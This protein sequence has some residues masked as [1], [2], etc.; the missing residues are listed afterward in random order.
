MKPTF[1]NV[2][3]EI[4]TKAEPKNIIRDFAEHTFMLYSGLTKSEDH[5]TIFEIAEPAKTEVETI[6]G[7]AKL[8]ARMSSEARAEWESAAARVFDFGYEV[9]PTFK[10]VDVNI[11][12][13]A[14][15]LIS[16][17]GATMRITIYRHDKNNESIE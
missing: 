5:L 12:L 1:L 11:D 6:K 2:D 8:I 13:E 15:R 7:F 3:L 9:E 17:C 16:A 4:T 14:T 10:M